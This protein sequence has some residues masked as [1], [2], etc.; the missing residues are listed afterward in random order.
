MKAKLGQCAG[1]KCPH[2]AINLSPEKKLILAE[3]VVG[4]G[5]GGALHEYVDAR[6]WDCGTPGRH[7]VRCSIWVKVPGCDDLASGTALAEGGNHDRMTR[8]FEQACASAGVTLVRPA[9]NMPIALIDEGL[10]AIAKAAGAKKTL[11][12]TH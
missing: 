12:V 9:D 7:A 10:N 1:K 11:T 8:A 2:N 5:K 6:W 3:S 4:V